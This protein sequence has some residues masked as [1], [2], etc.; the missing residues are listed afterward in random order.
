MSITRF[1]HVAMPR[2]EQA[3]A[4]PLRGVNGPAARRDTEPFAVGAVRGL[5]ECGSLNIKK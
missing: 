5:S 4:C 2:F 3:T 1:R